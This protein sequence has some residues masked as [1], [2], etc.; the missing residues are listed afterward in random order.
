[1]V[2]ASA[3][4]YTNNLTSL[5]TDNHTNT[6]SCNF[7]KSYALPATQPT[8][9]KHWRQILNYLTEKSNSITNINIKHHQ[10]KNASSNSWTGKYYITV[11]SKNSLTA[12]SAIPFRS[13][14]GWYMCCLTVSMK[15][16]ISLSYN[17][18]RFVVYTYR[19]YTKVLQYCHLVNNDGYSLYCI[20]YTVYYN[21][22]S[23]SMVWPTLGSRMAKEQNRTTVFHPR[24]YFLFLV[25]T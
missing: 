4:P 20:P 17:L 12:M 9:S 2:V 13:E 1:M 24:I 22:Q 7:Y 14:R 25:S 15:S 3:G 23:T 8:V 6:S 5:Q 18:F 16:L 19:H 10:L 11:N 21:G